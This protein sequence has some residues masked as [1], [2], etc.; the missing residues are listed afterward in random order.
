VAASNPQYS[1]AKLDVK[2]AFIP[3]G[4]VWYAG[5]RGMHREIERPS[6]GYLSIIKQ[7]CRGRYCIKLSMDMY[8]HP[9]YGS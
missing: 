9:S 8:R 6:T 4:D 5:V 2:G 7:V 3:N 1:I